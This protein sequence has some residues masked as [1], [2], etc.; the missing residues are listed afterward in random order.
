MGHSRPVDSFRRAGCVFAFA[1][2]VLVV[3]L[4]LSPLLMHE[5][6]AAQGQFQLRRKLLSRQ[7]AL[8]A[9]AFFA[10]A[11]EKHDARRPE[12]LK[13]MKIRRRFFDVDGYRKK[14]LVDEVCQLFI[15]IRFGFQPNA[16]P[17]GRS[18]AEIKQHGFIPA[19][20]LC[21]RSIGIFDPLH[22]H[23]L[24]SEIKNESLLLMHT[25]LRGSQKIYRD[26]ALRRKTGSFMWFGNF[27]HRAGDLFRLL[28]QRQ[29]CLRDNTD[30]VSL[31]IHHGNAP[32]L[33]RLH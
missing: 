8:D 24:T 27:G 29:I 6:D 4:G 16:C 10:G 23:S 2:N 7:I 17:S 13:T 25:A 15:A 33:V 26:G 12:R 32:E 20:G 19:F 11:V 5:R 22:G 18:G 21:Q 3:F 28:P 14:I 1:E 9:I 31:R 30:A